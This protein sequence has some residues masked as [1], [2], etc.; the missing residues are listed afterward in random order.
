MSAGAFLWIKAFHVIAAFAWMAGLLYLPRLF[1]YHADSPPGSR[2]AATFEVMERR[3]AK[4]IMLPAALATWILGACLV[5]LP[6]SPVDPGEGWF[7][8]KLAAVVGLTAVHVLLE[9]GRRAFAGGRNRR[10][11]RFW[12][13]VNEVPTV[14]LVI[15]VVAVV[16]RPL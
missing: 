2:R 3:L 14:L 10:T 13:I 7:T 1:V 4:A 9:R 6:G 5:L 12:R 8:L 11:S 15:A 16:V